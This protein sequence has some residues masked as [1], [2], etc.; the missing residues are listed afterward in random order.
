MYLLS[1]VQFSEGAF[2][3]VLDKGALDALMGDSEA[4]STEKAEQYLQEVH[5]SH[6]L[7]LQRPCAC[8]YCG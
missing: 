1:A 5:S 8:R 7:R 2:D 4:D 6:S 3:V